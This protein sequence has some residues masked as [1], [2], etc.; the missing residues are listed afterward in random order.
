MSVLAAD[1][2]VSTLGT[3]VKA[4]FSN[5]TAT[6]IYYRGALVYIDTG[7]GVQVVPA[8]GDRF[9]G[10]SPMKQSVTTGEEVEVYV[11]GLFWMPLCANSSAAD[12]G[13][14]VVLD[15]GSTQSD[16]IA[17]CVCATDIT[18]ATTDVIIGQILRVKTAAMLIAITPG[19]AGRIYASTAANAWL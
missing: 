19:L 14:L 9:L 8:A 7:G 16:N 3:P 12:E 2:N 4:T 13:D 5:N 18:A 11:K 17:D 15:M 10:I 1:I 6:E